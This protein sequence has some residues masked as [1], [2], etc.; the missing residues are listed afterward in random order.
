ML[1]EN[2]LTMEDRI[3]LAIILPI[4]YFVASII[5][6]V[7]RFLQIMCYYSLLIIVLPDIANC[8]F[9]VFGDFIPCEV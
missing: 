7:F 1:M 9:C 3:C 5:G 4:G 6:T 8:E 2:A